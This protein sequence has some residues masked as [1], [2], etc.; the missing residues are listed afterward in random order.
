MPVLPLEGSSRVA[1]G[2][3]RPA[4]SASSTICLA[5]RSLTLPVG[6][7]L[8]SLAHRRTPGFGDSRGRPTSGVLPIASARSSWRMGLP[9][10]GH[11]AR[12]TACHRRKDG[13]HVAVVELGIERAEEAD[14]LVIDVDVH[15]AVQ[16][17]VRCE[18]LAGDAREA[19]LEVAEEVADGAALGLDALG[20]IRVFPQDGRDTNFH[21][22]RGDRTSW[23]EPA[24]ADHPPTGSGLGA[25]R[26]STS[27][28]CPSRMLK[29]RRLGAFRSASERIR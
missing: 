18:Q 14:V 8:S 5:M 20:A 17:T 28:T 10:F 12:G 23:R 4:F 19:R 3:S 15:E 13:D 7:W 6:F 9:A 24:H 11:P 27:L 21:G 2:A 16:P 29:P 26:T 22:H 25:T 1:P